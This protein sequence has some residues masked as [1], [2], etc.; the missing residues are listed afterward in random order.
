M[1]ISVERVPKDADGSFK[2]GKSSQS[3]RA[4]TSAICPLTEA[5]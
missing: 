1:T 5:Q 2:S 4:T 3:I